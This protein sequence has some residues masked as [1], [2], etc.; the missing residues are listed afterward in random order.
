MVWASS[1]LD[2]NT[3]QTPKSP[4]SALSPSLERKM[5]CGFKSL[6]I[7]FLECMKERPNKI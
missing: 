4:I 2:S 5:L 6:C 7:M 3:R 1:C